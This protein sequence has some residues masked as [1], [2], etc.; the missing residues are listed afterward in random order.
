MIGIGGGIILSP[1]LLL[2]CWA[3]QKQAAAISAAFIFVNSLS[4]LAGQLTRGIQLNADMLWYVLIAFIGGLCGAY[5]GA[6]RFPQRILKN[7]LA[8]V[9][10]LAVYKLLFTQA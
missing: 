4:G 1:V 6:L 2:L 7:I 8:S 9:L 10:L 3:D 5:F